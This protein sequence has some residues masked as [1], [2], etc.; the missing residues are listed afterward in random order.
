MEA[1]WTHNVQGTRVEKTQDA[2]VVDVDTAAI[3][4]SSAVYIPLILLK[5]TFCYTFRVF[6]FNIF[7]INIKIF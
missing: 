2:D 5:S 3:G 4:T 6:T 7:G 1:E